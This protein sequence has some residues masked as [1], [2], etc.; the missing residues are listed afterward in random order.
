MVE[1][2]R[3]QDEGPVGAGRDVERTAD[4]VA[5]QGQRQCEDGEAVP[6][7]VEQD[8]GGLGARRAGRQRDLGDLVRTALLVRVETVGVGTAGG[9]QSSQERRVAGRGELTAVD[10][11]DYLHTV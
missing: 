11:H 1:R 7:D 5:R 4:V 3:L 2:R 6:A 8:A 9:R 10:V